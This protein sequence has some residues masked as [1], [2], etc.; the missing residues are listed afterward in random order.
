MCI[1][2]YAQIDSQK[3]RQ[4]ERGKTEERKKR[5]EVIKREGVIKRKTTKPPKK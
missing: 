3:D 2:M 1:H 4:R 5:E